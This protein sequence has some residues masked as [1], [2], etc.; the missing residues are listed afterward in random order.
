[1]AT[2]DNVDAHKHNGIRT[3][4]GAE[5]TNIILGQNG[6]DILLGV[7]DTTGVEFISGETGTDTADIIY[8]PN[9]RF[10]VAFKAINGANS[11]IQAQSLQGDHLSLDGT[12]HE[13]SADI[14]DNINLQD[15]DIINGCFNRIRICDAATY[16]LAYRG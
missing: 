1:M 2:V 15:Q 6:F 3:Y 9:T 5:A 11:S 14:T 12:Y 10:W 8:K 16:V 7:A 4:S 13:S